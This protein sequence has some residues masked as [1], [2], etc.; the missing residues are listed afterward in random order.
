MIISILVHRLHTDFRFTDAV[1]Q[2]FSSYLTDRTQYVSLCNYYV[3]APVHWCSSGLALFFSP[4]ILSLCL[5]LLIHT[6]THHLFAGD[7]QFQTSAPPDNI[8]A[9]LHS[10]LSFICDVKTFATA[11]MLRLNNDK[12]ELMLVTSKGS[13][14]PHSLPTSITNGNAQL[15]FKHSVKNLG[16]TFVCHLNMNA[17][18]STF[19]RTCY[20]ELRH[21]AYLPRFLTSTAK[22][23]LVSA[24]ALS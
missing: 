2:W 9:L 13:K 16:F 5:S 20:F 22:A 14:H 12:T 7:L 4:C 11:N 19:A 1:L 23:T 17:H 18:V 8:S 15:P 24:F 3:F 10:M 6:I 21:L